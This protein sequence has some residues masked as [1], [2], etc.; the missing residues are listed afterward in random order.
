M[1]AW[2]LRNIGCVYNKDDKCVGEFSVNSIGFDIIGSI[3]RYLYVIDGADINRMWCAADNLQ[4]TNPN[5]NSA[6]NLLDKIYVLIDIVD[7]TNIPIS[8]ISTTWNNNPKVIGNLFY[9]YSKI[10]EGVYALC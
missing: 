6:K 3:P 8:N 9:Y 4:E 10:S 5:T 1:I 7:V 2:A